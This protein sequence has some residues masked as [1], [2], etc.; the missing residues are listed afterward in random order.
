M[1]RGNRLYNCAVAVHRGGRILAVVPKSYLPNYREFYERRWFAPPGD[2]RTGTIE[3]AGQQAPPFG[4]DV[5][6]TATDLPQL[7][8][9]LEVCED[10]WVPVQPSA[11]AALAG[12]ATVLVN[13][14]GSPITIAKAEDRHLLV[15]S[16]SARCLAGYVYAAAGGEG[17]SS[18]DLSW[19]GQTM[20]YECGRLLAESARFPRAGAAY[21]GR[22]RPGLIVQ[23]RLRQGSFD[24]NARTHADRVARFRTA[25][26]TLAPPAGDVGLRRTVARFPFVPDDESRLAQDCYEATRSRSPGWSSG[27][28]RSVSPRW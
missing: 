21:G 17:E 19:D 13:L 9:H 25:E 16:Q 5:I 4:P 14:S 27:C 26:F 23:E 7:R 12:G 20:V 2:D 10:L 24:D 6:L 28:A 3:V 15:G 22:H 1:R 18:T 8:I 11:E